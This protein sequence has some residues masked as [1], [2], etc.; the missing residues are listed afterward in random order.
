MPI[1]RYI[2][3]TCSPKELPPGMSD[4]VKNIKTA[5]PGFRHFLYSESDCRTFISTHFGNDVL[6]A[7]DTLILSAFKTDL[8]KYCVLFKCGGV[9]VDIKYI[10]VRGFSFLDILHRNHLVLDDE[11]TGIHTDFMACEPGLPLLAQCISRIVRHVQTQ[12]YGSSPSEVTG[13]KLITQFIGLNDPMI[14]LAHACKGKVKQILRNNQLLLYSYPSYQAE[15]GPD[16]IPDPI[17]TSWA[18][19]SIYR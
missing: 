19:R 9:F 16:Q 4:A 12:F 17:L 1:P 14:D 3:Q 7:Y 8:W 6:T 11:R 13:S 18:T 5:N 2:F 15:V 10:P